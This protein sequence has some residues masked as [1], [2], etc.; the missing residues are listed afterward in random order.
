MENKPYGTVLIKAAKI[1][2]FISDHP[3]CTLQKIVEGTGLTASTASKIL[4]TL[5]LIGYVS[6]NNEYKEFSIG[7]KFIRYANKNLEQ[8]DLVEIA[9]P[10]L[11][12]LQ[13]KVNETIHLGIL[14]EDK[15]L[16]ID[17][18]EPENQTIV[19]SSKI[20]ITRPLY[21]SAMGKAA[22]S[23][24]S[25][26]E[27]EEYLQRTEFQPF[28]EHTITNPLKL[29]KE[30]E[31][32]K[33]SQIAF[34]DEEI[35]HD[36]FCFGVSLKRDSELIGTMSISMPKYRLTKEKHTAIINELLSTKNAI[37]QALKE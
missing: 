12:E 10:F 22:L 26:T 23:E 33:E 30:V 31:K 24:F 13:K 1:L 7:T 5:L 15:I 4:D 29:L 14:S 28:T 17:K 35:E 19:M 18:L 8:I 37:E 16:Y 27:L 32:V 20:G 21:N 11:V 2:D 9:H 36:I 25:K 3:K 6:K 34:D